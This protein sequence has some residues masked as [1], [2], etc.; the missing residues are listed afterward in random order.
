MENEQCPVYTPLHKICIF[1]S[2]IGSLAISLNLTNKIHNYSIRHSIQIL[3]LLNLPSVLA[4]S[5][6]MVVVNM[7][8]IN[9]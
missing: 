4:D 7:S 6:M 9:F 8:T 3:N 1:L 2:L 5:E